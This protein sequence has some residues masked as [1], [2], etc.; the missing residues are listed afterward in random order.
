MAA[1]N[2]GIDEVMACP[3]RSAAIWF[4]QA[5]A[6]GDV[7]APLH[8]AKCLQ[9][10]NNNEGARLLKLRVDAGPQESFTVSPGTKPIRT[11]EDDDFDEARNLL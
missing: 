8:L 3:T 7:D 9:Q 2:F 6:L 10:G 11:L 1:L 5:I 4:Q